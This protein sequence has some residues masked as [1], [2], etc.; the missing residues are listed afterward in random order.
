MLI[1]SSCLIQQIIP[2]LQQRHS[3]TL[4][5]GD[6]DTQHGHCP[7]RVTPGKSPIGFFEINVWPQNKAACF[8]KYS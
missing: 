1:I 2:G 3:M 6:E 5:T 7:Q 8:E 4:Y